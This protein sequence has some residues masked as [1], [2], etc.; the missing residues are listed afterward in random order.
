MFYFLIDGILV[1]QT[2]SFLELVGF[3]S[4]VERTYVG[5]SELK[6]LYDG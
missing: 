5:Y 4:W 1:Y 6:I 3:I 2:D